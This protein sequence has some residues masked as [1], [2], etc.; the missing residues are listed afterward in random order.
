MA[1][2]SGE[3]KPAPPNRKIKAGTRLLREWQGRVHEV[4][5]VKDG[6]SYQGSTYCS[7]SEIARTITGTRWN[8]WVF[9]A[10]RKTSGAAAASPTHG[11]KR[12]GPPARQG[13]CRRRALAQGSAGE[14]GARH[15]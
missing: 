12:R 8:G 7:L 10:L 1:R 3:P 15:A 14:E 2:T 11:A 4:T 6:F 13:S 9:F 5:V